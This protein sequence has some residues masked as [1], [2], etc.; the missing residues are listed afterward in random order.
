MMSADQKKFS[1]AFMNSI[2]ADVWRRGE[3]WM[4]SVAA[5]LA[6]L[7]AGADTL[8]IRS[9]LSKPNF[10]SQKNVNCSQLFAK[11]TIF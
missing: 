2:P 7:R 9:L 3:K 5:G 11:L 6:S 4:T 10:R 8:F 1:I